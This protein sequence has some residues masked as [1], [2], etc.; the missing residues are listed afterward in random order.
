MNRKVYHLIMS[1]T[2]VSPIRISGNAV[3]GLILSI[4]S[5]FTAFLPII[6]ILVGAAAAGI[7]GAGLWQ[8]Q[9]GDRYGRGVA[10]AGIT[11][12]SITAFVSFLLTLMA[13]SS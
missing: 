4:L 1:N 12:G 11:I 3:F 7:S 8:V 10:A 6:G 5:L 2:Q 9:R 13:F